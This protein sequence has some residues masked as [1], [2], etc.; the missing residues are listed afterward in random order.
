MSR[1]LCFFCAGSGSDGG[2][3]DCSACHGSG[4][5]RFRFSEKSKYDAKKLARECIERAFAQVEEK[6][7]H[8]LFLGAAS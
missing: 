6:D 1:E 4:F 3:E 2:G 5:Q 8:E 7:E